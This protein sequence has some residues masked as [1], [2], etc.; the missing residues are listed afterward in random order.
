MLIIES[1]IKMKN[2]LGQ[3]FWFTGLSGAGKTSLANAFSEKLNHHCVL[4]DGDVLR[5]GLC[6]DLGFS[7]KDREENIRRVAEVS[8]LFVNEGHIVLASFISPLFRHRQMA[9]EIISDSQFNEVFVDT[10]IDICEKRDIKGLYKK[11]RSGLIKEFTGIDSPY[12]SPQNPKFHFTFP[13]DV[14]E[15]S[16]ELYR[17]VSTNMIVTR[18]V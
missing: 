18:K 10:S 13:F 16:E 17:F 6:R 9:R 1:M 14:S 15:A 8:K 7:L 4:L 5:L 11:A 3:V 2:R 12:E